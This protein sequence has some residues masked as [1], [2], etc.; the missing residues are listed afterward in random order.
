MQTHSARAR[1]DEDNGV[2]RSRHRPE[3]RLLDVED[4]EELDGPLKAKRKG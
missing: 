4:L 1:V 3:R 2:G